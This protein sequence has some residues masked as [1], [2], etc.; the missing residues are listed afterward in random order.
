[1]F[2][3]V[4]SDGGKQRLIIKLRYDDTIADVR[5]YIDDHRCVTL[6]SLMQ[7]SQYYLCMQ[8]DGGRIR[9]SDSDPQQVLR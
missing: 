6:S 4:K 1:M 7:V 3:Q 2:P 8:D 5:K 9:A